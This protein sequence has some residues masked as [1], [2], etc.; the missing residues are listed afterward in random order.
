MNNFSNVPVY[1]G[2][3][4]QDM[5][6]PA[7][8]AP[9]SLATVEQS[10]AIAET[11]AAMI[12]AQK[13]PR[14]ENQAYNKIMT[15]CKRKSLAASSS[16]A[17]R[18][19]GALVTGPSIRLAEVLARCWGNMTYGFREINRD[20][21]KSEVEAFC[22]DQET[23]VRVTRTLSIKHYRDKKS[24]PQKLKAERDKYEHIASQAQRRV[25]A[26]ILEMIPG[27][28]IEAAEDQCRKT[29][30]QEDG[31]PIEDRVRDMLM[32]FKDFGVTEA[33]IEDFLSHK[34]TA[35]APAELVRLQQV[36]RS[37][38]D[39]VAPREEFFNINLE[40]KNKPKSEPKPKSNKKGKEPDAEQAE[41]EPN[42]LYETPEW[43]KYKEACEFAPE[44]AKQ[45]PEPTTVDD[46]IKAADMI[47]RAIDEQGA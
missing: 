31:R 6:F 23:N 20:G 7:V 4:Q 39:G 2:Q 29:L 15:A 46:C 24:G 38:K 22:W 1:S 32:A 19:G 40:S 21:D 26:C 8:Q 13:F 9:S 11:Q 35:I 42:P 12:V 17:F 25:R 16:Y 36:Y 30:E 41:E 33:M 28:F 5:S 43:A 10:R 34:I 3:P 37:I 44:L 45:F 18:R 14:N 47:S 27:D